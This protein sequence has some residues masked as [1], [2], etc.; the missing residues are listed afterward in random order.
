MIS[1]II[2]HKGKIFAMDKIS[3]IVTTYKRPISILQRAINSIVNQTYSNIEIIVV[4]DAPQLVDLVEEIRVML[5]HYNT[6]SIK[7]IVQPKNMGA[8]H[9]RNTGIE[10]AT[11]KYVAFLDDDDEWLPDKLEKQYSLI[12]KEKVDL[13]YCSHFE[14]NRNGTRKL[15][16][17]ELAREGIHGDE[18]ERLLLANFVGST[19][20]PLLSLDAVK[21]V[22]GFDINLKSS[23]DHDLWLRIAKN[24]RI[25]YCNEPLVNYYFS[26]ESISTS[27]VNKLQG[28]NYIFNK[29][30][31][32]YYL[33]KNMY[34]YRLNY[35]AYCCL[36]SRYYKG[37]FL[38]TFQAIK[39][40]V[41][42]KYN[43]MILVKL[44]NKIKKDFLHNKRSLL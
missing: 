9:A 41:S 13:V 6:N 16:I 11:G 44:I 36:K 17:E 28:F 26:E 29:Y 23:Q 15:V 1:N 19:S 22:G 38:F 2:T 10:H 25:A 40:K 42:S 12:C 14:I 34:N 33:D 30:K 3:C 21:S 27:I 32:L 35:I 31:N 7:Y 37:F 8:C 24:Y 5:A 43:F 4:N 20:Y 18:F 39:V